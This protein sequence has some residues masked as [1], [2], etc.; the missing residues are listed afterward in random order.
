MGLFTLSDTFMTAIVMIIFMVFIGFVF[1]LHGQTQIEVVSENVER[2]SF[3][4]IDNLMLSDLTVSYGVFDF[5]KLKEADLSHL[6]AVRNCKYGYGVSFIFSPST[7]ITEH[8][9]PVLNELFEY[10]IQKDRH[11][12][13]YAI[14]Y[15][16]NKL[17]FPAI[18]FG[19][20]GYLTKSAF[21]DSAITGMYKDK[22]TPEGFQ[23]DVNT[24]NIQT[25]GSSVTSSMI[26]PVQMPATE[27][28]PKGS[29][30]FALFVVYVYDDP[31]SRFSCALEQAM[32]LSNNNSITI[33]YSPDDL[34]GANKMNVINTTE[35][36][37]LC[38]YKGSYQR[39]CRKL[40]SGI[41]I[42]SGALS[43]SIDRNP[44][45]ILKKQNNEIMWG[46]KELVEV[47]S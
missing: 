9:S 19:Y 43:F 11:P 16:S 5:E 26:V 3:E 14:E 4:I 40:V 1:V 44:A 27:S 46:I 34:D 31:L 22:W 32:K 39:V 35:G 10:D 13:K 41:K 47:E 8:P 18:H 6:E 25:L 28:N 15:R 7:S 17:F 30:E 24:G 29:M 37:M 12:S 33:T 38:F 21:T 23:W 45:L 20:F 2:A 36:D 42:S